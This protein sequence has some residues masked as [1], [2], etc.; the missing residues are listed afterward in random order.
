MSP[1]TLQNLMRIS[2]I[3]QTL[4]STR[5]SLK[6]SVCSSVCSPT[7]RVIFEFWRKELCNGQFTEIHFFIVF[8]LFFVFHTE[9]IVHK[10][11]SCGFPRHFLFLHEHRALS[12]EP[13]MLVM[14]AATAAPASV[15]FESE[16]RD[17]AT[18]AGNAGLPRLVERQ[19]HAKPPRG[20]TSTVTIWTHSS[21]RTRSSRPQ[22]CKA[23]APPWSPTKNLQRQQKHQDGHVQ[24]GDARPHRWHFGSTVPSHRDSPRSEGWPSCAAAVLQ[25]RPNCRTP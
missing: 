14:V 12:C 2:Q 4:M 20:A 25:C 17:R 1:I 9:Y 24:H 11:I 13:H 15:I 18:A 21:E 16:G 6:N 7:A 10:R 8:V 3:C 19:D 23:E 22:P 5:D